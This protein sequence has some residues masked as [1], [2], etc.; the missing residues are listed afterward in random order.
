MKIFPSPD[1]LLVN[2]LDSS[3]LSAFSFLSSHLSPLYVAQGGFWCES[4][5]AFSFWKSWKVIY[6]LLII[7]EKCSFYLVITF[8]LLT[9]KLKFLFNFVAN[10]NVSLKSTSFSLVFDGS[11]SPISRDNRNTHPHLMTIRTY[12]LSIITRL[13]S[14]DALNRL[15]F[16]DFVPFNIRK[17]L[18]RQF[19]DFFTKYSKNKIVQILFFLP[20]NEL[21]MFPAF[22]WSI[23]RVCILTFFTIIMSMKNLLKFLR[24]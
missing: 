17:V 11:F 22:I 9:I 6:T 2:V 21:C 20:K 13:L 24:N 14:L 16:H 1:S 5:D 10:V 19:L 4:P 18:G 15:I 12:P 8:C 23:K 7:L 3:L